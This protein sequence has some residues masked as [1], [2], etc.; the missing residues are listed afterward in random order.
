MVRIKFSVVFI[1]AA[2]A[3]AP[4]LALPTPPSGSSNPQDNV[5][6]PENPSTQPEASTS[7]SAPLPKGKKRRHQDEVESSSS[8]RRKV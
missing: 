8:K 5:G 4:V 6:R 3:I 7:R 2:A 1:L